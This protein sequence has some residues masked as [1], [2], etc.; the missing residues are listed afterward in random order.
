MRD[1]EA[2]EIIRRAKKALES[3]ESLTSQQWDELGSRLYKAREV[4]RRGLYSLDDCDTYLD[5][6]AL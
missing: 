6:I 2:L 5:R 3:G 4:R 1:P